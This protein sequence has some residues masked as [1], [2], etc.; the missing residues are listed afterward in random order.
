MKLK[1]TQAPE[2]YVTKKGR[3]RKITLTSVDVSMS[4]DEIKNLIQELQT[5]KQ[6]GR[7]K[8]GYHIHLSDDEG[9]GR[10]WLEVT[11]YHE[12]SYAPQHYSEIAI[13]NEGLNE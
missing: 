1:T 4:T 9:R 12:K 5:L 2:A 8:T 6:E 10:H 7:K 13:L 3:R 11:L